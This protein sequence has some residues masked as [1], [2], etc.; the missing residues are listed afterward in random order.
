MNRIAINV[1]IVCTVLPCLFP[2]AQGALLFDEEETLAVVIE[3]PVNDLV[4][5]RRNR[6]EHRG[7]L[8]FT[9]ATGE[10]R[11][12]PLTVSVRGHSRLRLCNYPPVKLKFDREATAGT[13][14]DNQRS[15][16]L[17]TQC[18]R[19]ISA[20]DW[21]ALEFAAYR[22]YNAVTPN[23]Y[24]VR[25][26]EV[27]WRDTRSGKERVQP[28]F[29]IESDKQAA[30]R[31][32]VENIRPPEV[33]PEQ[34]SLVDTTHY[35]L[36]QYLIGNTDF[37]V[38]R[39]PRGEGCCHNGRVFV[40]AGA[41]RDYIF[42]PYDFDQSGMVDT[43]YA[44]PN[45][46]FGIASVTSRVYRGFC[47]QNEQLPESVARFNAVRPQIEAAFLES[48]ISDRQ[49]R[50]VQRYINKFYA[51]VNNREELQKRM[52]DKCRGPDSLPLRASPVSPAHLRTP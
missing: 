3:A 52:L 9:E 24:R 43:D 28:A 17:V 51:I 18:T 41:S 4:H 19:D 2:V 45:S 46:A 33:L 7:I 34:M 48:G 8:R 39:G 16:K 22:A 10:E 5:R 21:V 44:K 13:L 36:F 23:S 40:A 11:A 47:W 12:L 29:L 15:L 30:Q 31:L 1:C 25:R 20:A 35:M 38:K 42:L 26:L 37:A 50:R 32:G 27:T 14:F 49:K 6:P